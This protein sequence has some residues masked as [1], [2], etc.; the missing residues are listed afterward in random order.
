MKLQNGSAPGAGDAATPSRPA[1][2]GSSTEAIRQRLLAG[3]GGLVDLARWS[4]RCRGGLLW[5]TT[6]L[7]MLATLT[8]LDMVVRREEI[9]L[10]VL[11]LMLWTAATIV[12]TMRWLIPAWR[13][14]PTRIEVARWIERAQPE[15][16][17]QLSTA[18][19]FAETAPT[20]TRFGSNQFREVVL[21]NWSKQSP[22]IAWNAYLDHTSWLRPA[23]LLLGVMILVVTASVRRPDEARLALARLFQPWANLPWPQAD[24]LAFVNLPKALASGQELQLEIIDRVPPLP[25]RIDVYVRRADMI[26]TSRGTTEATVYSASNL[27]DVAVVTI[28]SIDQAIEIRA[29][30]GADRTMPWQRID[31]AQPPQLASFRFQV[32]PPA[33]SGRPPMEIVGNR[34]QVLARSRVTFAGQFA[35]AV[36]SVE[37]VRQN[38]YADSGLAQ[39]KGSQDAAAS[40]LP[41]SLSDGTIDLN[42]DERS[43]SFVVSDE[44]TAASVLN[45]RLRVTTVAGVAITSPEIWAVEI[46]ADAPPTVV[47]AEQELAQIS[48]DVKL[49]LR[50]KASDDLGLSEVAMRWQ[51]ENTDMTEPGRWALW[52]NSDEPSATRREFNVEQVWQLDSQLPLVAGQRLQIWLEATDTLGQLGKSSPQSLE[53]RDAQDVLE[54]IAGRQSQLLEQVRAITEAQRRNSQLA[55][56]S[57]EIIQQSESVRR[58][59]ADA[60]ANVAQMQQS[61]NR[62]MNAER[63]SVAESLKTLQQLLANN[64]LTDSD[65]AA[66]VADLAQRVERLRSGSLATAARDAQAALDQANQLVSNK[67]KTEQSF[68]DALAN[69]ETSQTNALAELQEL[70]DRLAQTE[71]LRVVERELSQLLNQQQALRRETDNLEIRRLSGLSK[72]EFQ[73]NRTGLQAD[74]QGLAQALEQLEK[75]ARALAAEMPSDQATLSA[76]IE[77]AVAGLTDSQVSSR[78]RVAAENIA[79]DRFAAAAESQ[80]VIVESLRQALQQLSSTSQRSLE[81]QLA[82][83]QATAAELGQLAAAQTVLAD[84]LAAEN[85]LTEAAGL[86]GEQA[87]LQQATSSQ[88][89]RAEQAGDQRTGE[90]L[91]RA[92][93]SQSSASRAAEQRLLPAAANSARQAAEELTKAAQDSRERAEQI[94]REVTE[95]QTVQLATE[96]AQLVTQQREVVAK[97]YESALVRLGELE[98]EQRPTKE[99]E[100]R[101]LASRQEAVRQMT[102]DVRQRTMRLPTFDWVLEQAE[103]DMS[104]AVAAAQR[105]R[106]SPDATTS[107]DRA[108]RKL[109]QAEQ[110]MQNSPTAGKEE[111]AADSAQQN[112]G[113]Q[114]NPVRPA[115][116]IASLKLMRAL[117]GDINQETLQLNVDPTTLDANER[118]QRIE[119]LSQQQQA[120]G[121]QMEKLLRELEAA[122]DNNQ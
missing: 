23:G 92:S 52:S 39:A 7:V 27:T 113:E 57:R 107:A 3:V 101:Q 60:L 115:P 80:Q 110:A 99:Q 71:A 51:I 63:N 15:L 79:A 90:Q 55:A 106:I 33:Y 26:S 88:Q 91:A 59:E 9:G 61:V 105:F 93:E 2:V 78:M 56:R 122:T 29:V 5:L 13:F 53:V 22:A 98:R 44:T 49:P 97:L 18:V 43:F 117:Q 62:Q 54:S 6:V 116:P 114:G 89:A 20:D 94:Q 81:G 47:L 84:K 1:N 11:F 120:L 103:S 8:S 58:E 31:V 104:R 77:R 112:Q 37:V 69:S 86:A 111:N 41:T 82:Q 14:S 67:L 40:P 87:Q 42:E 16:G 121:L 25:E 65:T 108:L 4:Y 66:T 100:L 64:Q 102:R 70:T 38:T 30:G 95:Q 12:A 10:R 109:E 75:L 85:A 68:R 48:S 35:E 83:R 46:L 50:G 118:V 21:Q 72:E 119:E 28:P 32:D 76:Q 96:L 34:I 74:Q 17:E 45:W 36:R 73:A 24:Q 19:Q